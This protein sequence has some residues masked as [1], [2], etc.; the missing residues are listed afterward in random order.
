MTGK[1]RLSLL[2]TVN[3]K[4][5]VILFIV[6]LSGKLLAQSP[7]EILLNVNYENNTLNSGITG[8]NPTNATASDAVYMVQPG[9]TGSYAA[10]HKV[11]YGDQGYYSND[12]WRSESDADRFKAARFLP[13]DERRYEFSVLLKDWTPWK[14]GDPANET[15]I[16]QLKI[17]GGAGVPLQVRTQ[18]NAMRLRF[19]VEN[20]VPVTDIIPDIRPYIN[21]W[22]HFRID[23]KWTDTATG[24]MKTYMKLPAQN[25]YV[26]VDHKENYRTYSG[27][28][29]G[30]QHGYIKWG[31]YV[32]PP[33]ITRVAYHDDIK[34]IYL[35]GPAPGNLLGEVI[36]AHRH[37]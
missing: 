6:L 20:N 5:V 30:G 1:N 32:T 16:F 26:L 13:G 22:I 18:R 37:P 15:N 21:Q 35:G 23:V 28:G 11:V 4:D 27:T 19:A 8:V 24:Y 36:Y 9:A 14:A 2:F 12:N 29:L 25:D 31:I 7:G 33:D 3:K 34:V 17:S 10:A